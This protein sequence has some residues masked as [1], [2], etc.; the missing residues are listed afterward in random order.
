MF[1]KI[2]KIV[3]VF[4]L[5]AALFIPL[6]PVSAAPPRDAIN[7]SP[8]DWVFSVDGHSG[9]SNGEFVYGP[10]TPPA[11][12]GSAMLSVD[13]TNGGHI[14]GNRNLYNGERLSRITRLSYSTYRSSS[15]PAN[16]LAIALQLNINLGDGGNPNELEA[17]LVYEP[18]KSGNTVPANTWQTW[19]TLASGNGSGN[20]WIYPMNTGANPNG[21]CPQSNACTW[22]EF[23]GY[24]PNATFANDSVYGY[25]L[26]GL[27][28]KAGSGWNAFTG[29]VDNLIVGID[30]T[31]DYY[32]FGAETARVNQTQSIAASNRTII[33]DSG[34]LTSSFAAVAVKVDIPLY[35]PPGNTEHDDV[36]N[37][38]N[39]SLLRNGTQQISIDKID[40]KEYDS[41][42]PYEITVYFNH[43]ENLPNGEYLFT[44]EGDTSVVTLDRIPIAGD[45]IHAGT[46]F[47]IRFTIN[48]PAPK[49][50]PAVLPKTGF[51]HGTVTSLP[52][53]PLSQAYTKTELTLEIPKLGLETPIVGVPQNETGWDVTWLNDSAGWL[54]GTAFPTW[55]GNT[56]LTGHVWN[57]F[58][59]PGVFSR[60]NTLAYGDQV[61]IHAWGLTYTYEVRESLLVTEKNV[62]TVLRPEEYDW[63][64]LLT[65]E[66]YNP[67]T[68]DYLFRRAVKAVLIDIQ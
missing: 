53:Q 44:V 59:Q 55:N 46:D 11:G 42:G 1:R 38:V 58:N 43:G 41:N 6:R 10:G 54:N 15:D 52:K 19:D 62:A 4:I 29:Y 67:F 21:R 34:T 26:G 60:I 16:I 39:Y 64:T 56:V 22:Q 61:Q 57:S 63:L 8:S 32:D 12:T 68:G 23:I 40:Y 25:R 17:R 3:Q 36:T 37:T 48:V 24:F 33:R 20:W 31:D 30:G 50:A 28:F 35:N 14:L 18:Y 51:R 65:C 2:L 9:G 66:F 13:D 7:E 45:G 49:L 47:N 27:H 5:I